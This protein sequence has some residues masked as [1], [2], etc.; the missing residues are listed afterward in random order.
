MPS[1]RLLFEQEKNQLSNE[2]SY[3]EYMKKLYVLKKKYGVIAVE[4]RNNSHYECR[5]KQANKRSR[6]QGR[7]I[8]SLNLEIERTKQNQFSRYNEDKSKISE[9]IPPGLPIKRSKG[10]LSVKINGEDIRIEGKRGRPR[11]N[12]T[13]RL[14]STVKRIKTNDNTEHFAHKLSV[15]SNQGVGQFSLSRTALAEIGFFSC[16]KPI[17]N[18]EVSNKIRVEPPLREWSDVPLEIK[19]PLDNLLEP[20]LIF[21]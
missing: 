20:G 6:I 4:N 16:L 12:L 19:E 3:R 8:P 2:L 1:D 9:F 7:F 11:K 15:Q 10:I 14:D 18:E 13:S 21:N 17:W 5:K